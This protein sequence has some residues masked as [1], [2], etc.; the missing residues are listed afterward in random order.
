MRLEDHWDDLRFVLAVARHG[1]M[2]GAAR[3]LA[4]DVSTVSRRVERLAHELGVPLFEK[5]AGSWV[6]TGAAEDLADVA[7]TFEQTLRARVADIRAAQGDA[8][9]ALVI[10]APHAVHRRFVVPGLH[11]L[12]ARLP[13]V[14]VTLSKQAD[15]QGLGGADLQLRIGRPAQ[16]RV[17]ARKVRDF[18]LR[19]HHRADRPLGEDWVGLAPDGPDGEILRVLHPDAAPL[20][21]CRVGTVPTA[22]EVAEGTGLAVLAPDFL[23]PQEHSLVAADLPGNA[24]PRALW[25]AYH[26]SRHR[27]STLRAVADWLAE[28]ME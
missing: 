20:P 22:V 25:L 19:V 16:G 8:D 1:T 17:R 9:V 10:N 13:H 23:I 11:D 7:E 27:D 26:E 4:A 3:H 12:R 24:A 5:R 15:A 18:A 6:T 14:R 21:R 28:A 2:S